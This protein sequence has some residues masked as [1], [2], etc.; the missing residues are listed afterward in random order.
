MIYDSLMIHYGELS[1]KG[2]N[3][4]AFINT[5]YGNVKH[6]MK[7][8]DVVTS[9]THDFILVK[10]NCDF[11][12][13][14]SRLQEIP[15]IQKISLVA[16]VE[17][18]FEAMK[19]A[20]VAL[21]GQ[22]EGKTFKI[23]VHRVD[24]AFPSSSYEST[25]ILADAILDNTEKKVDLHNYDIFLKVAIRNDA[26]YLSCH[27][28]PGLGGYPL[29]MNGKVMHLLSG[30][31]DSPV[32]AYKLLRRGIGIE[33]IH[34]AAPPYTSSAVIDKLTD[35][36]CKLNVY[37]NSIKL[38][39]VPFTKLQEA[40]YAN[41]PEP[42]CITIMRRMMMRIAVGLAKKHHCL[43][44]STGES[45][46]QVA[47]QTLHSLLVINNVTNYPVLRPLAAE[48]K[49]AIIELSKKISTYEISIRPYEDCC[50][51]FKPKR[52]KT[53]PSLV[54]AENYEQRF[55]YQTLVDECIANVSCLY[56]EGGIVSEPAQ[57]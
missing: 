54:E 26:C 33:T 16:K 35:I 15:G 27:E 49:V 24:K 18:D 8:F 23:D 10:L 20:A 4:K 17:K 44:I 40:I 21:V 3:K 1:T 7:G 5:L 22:E 12:P 42:Y 48:D 2:N 57:Q 47:S 56:I 45:V 13:V 50:T 11:L 6:A 43:A 25:C 34:F 32:A 31:I 36:C 9:Y 53:M 28:Y 39:I 14:L 41:V 52:P 30:G 51:I 29:G 38:N 46:G 55:D 19:S 37:Q